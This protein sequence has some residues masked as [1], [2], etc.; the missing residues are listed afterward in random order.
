MAWALWF[1]VVS[2][3][4]NIRRLRLAVG[5]RTQKA[6]AETLHIPQ[7]QVSDWEND[8]YAVLEVSTLFKLA[9]ALRRPV[10]QLLAGVDPDYDHVQQ[11]VAPAANDDFSRRTLP[12]I[13]VV[14]EGHAAPEGIT[15]ADRRHA[16]HILSWLSRPRDLPDANA[17]GVQIR[18]D[19]ML[20]AYRPNMIAILSPNSELRDGDEAY[21]QLAS[22]EC[23]VRL[24]RTARDG[25]VLQTYNP[26]CTPRFVKHKAIKAMHVVVY[27]RR[28]L[29]TEFER[30]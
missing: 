8:R 17:Y 4:K 11:A 24:V 16:R 15:G 3:G 20:P 13:P 28:S 29:G 5:L 22:G 26:V 9:K 21:V 19:A 25:Y 7:P 2:L 12:D 1:R 23:R 10:H 14:P 18:D 27:S 6:L 30:A